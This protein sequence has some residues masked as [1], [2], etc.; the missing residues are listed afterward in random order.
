MRA[1]VEKRDG[2]I[3]KSVYASPYLFS[4]MEQNLSQYA[5]WLASA[6]F[7]VPDTRVSYKNG[8]AIFDQEL[9]ISCEPINSLEI[10]RRMRDMNFDFFGMDSNP[11]NFLGAR[12]PYF[13]DFFPFLIKEK[14]VLSEQF[15]YPT[16]IVIQRY[17]VKVNIISTFINRLFK[18]VPKQAVES[19]RKVSD[20]LLSEYDFI[21][22]REKS[23]LYK[24][25]EIFTSHGNL[26][27]YLDFYEAS[28]EV[29]L[30]TS[31]DNEALREFLK[32]V[33]K[34]D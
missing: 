5:M 19:V 23:R 31:S 18:S 17:F 16:E 29:E 28:K 4:A 1:E 6:G 3:I 15:D 9:I 27:D 8:L 11:N 22:P 24:G 21:L 14:N 25:L 20:F 12:N 32:T 13:V 34:N 30:I 7:R 33:G 26:L 2:R 10:I